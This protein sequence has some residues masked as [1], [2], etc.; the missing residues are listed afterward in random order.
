MISHQSAIEIKSSHAK[1][2][3][4]GDLDLK[5]EMVSIKEELSKKSLTD[6]KSENDEDMIKDMESE[7]SDDKLELSKEEKMLPPEIPIVK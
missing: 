2:S 3:S 1:T 4:N 5:S 7:I 6:M